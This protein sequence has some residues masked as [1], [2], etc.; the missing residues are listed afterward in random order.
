MAKNW[1]IK[2]AYD[3]LK[4]GDKAGV[5]D[6]GKRFPLATMAVSRVSGAEM[7]FAALPTH[8]TMRKVEMVLKDGVEVYTEDGE[9]EDYEAP[10]KPGSAK[11]KED[12]AAAKKT[13]GRPKTKVEEPE[14]EEEEDNPYEGMSAKELFKLC[15]K[16]HIDEAAPNRSVSYYIEF[17]KAAD[18]AATSQDTEDDEDDWDD[19]EVEE[20]KPAKKAAKKPVPA[21]KSAPAKKPVKREVAEEDD[22]GDDE[23]NI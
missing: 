11:A 15:R 4:T 21:K 8:L 5:L 13:K 2:E 17:L 9:S 6:F 1:T 10:V 14:E 18:E 19:D 23:W 12:L 3:C 20:E 7:L 16:R 22:E